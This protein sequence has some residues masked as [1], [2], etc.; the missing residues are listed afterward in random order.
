M[1]QRLRARF[2]AVS[3]FAVVGALA[4]GMIA[5]GPANAAISKTTLVVGMSADLD[6]LDPAATMDN[7]QWKITYPCYQRLVEYN[8]AST[9][10]VPGLASAWRISRDHLT[11]TFT[12][13]SGQKFSDGTAVTAKAVQYTFERLL[14]VAKGPADNFTA[15]ASVRANGL[16][17]VVFV[18][19]QVS[20]Q[21]LYTLAGNYGG[22]VN[23]A[24]ASK[25]VNGDSGQAYLADHT[26]GSGAYV[27][28]EWKKGQYLKL[29]QNKF[30]G[31]KKPVLE[32][33]LFKIVGD[34]SSQRLQL[35]KGEIDIAEGITSDQYAAV[36]KE[37]GNTVINK[38][39]LTVDIMY[40]NSGK[41]NAALKN[42]LVRQAIS[43]ALDYQGIMAATQAGNATQMNGPI[44]D[45]MWGQDPKGF[46]YTTNVTKAKALLAQAGVT[47]LSLDLLYSARKSWWASEAQLIQDNLAKAGIT[48]NLKL[49]E[50]ATARKMI[51]AGTFDLCL[52]T[53]SPDYAD[54]SMFM[55]FWFDSGNFGLAGNRSFYSNP[56]V[57]KLIR[58][59]ASITDQKK[60]TALYIQAQKIVVEEAAY[61]YLYQM[62]YRLALRTDVKGFVYNPMIEQ[63]YNLE[64][65]YKA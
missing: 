27:L 1:T 44:P 49:T 48:V 29:E 13:K 37:D 21:F 3:V 58:S 26:A 43:Y 35:G 50:Y 56:A 23:P 20:P 47:N 6:Y 4:L 24:T 63:I 11:Y 7:A 38:P 45:G 42:T 62:N 18:L 16:K 14:K 53:W 51:D 33:V 15:I 8:G 54:P 5:S 36:A 39:S 31:G 32:T 40:I 19:N 52:G 41:G 60:R 59:A 10:V 22:I 17:T 2:S 65:M 12:I 57:D 64:T 61:G 46:Q 28:T 55:N 9:D 25:A 34:A 30:Y